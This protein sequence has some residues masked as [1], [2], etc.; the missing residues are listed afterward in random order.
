MVKCPG[1][2]PIIPIAFRFPNSITTVPP[3]HSGLQRRAITELLKE[4]E[5]SLTNLFL[6]V[7]VK[8][9]SSGPF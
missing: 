9:I 5:A 2:E 8:G 6:T 4:A 3:V 7:M 1:I